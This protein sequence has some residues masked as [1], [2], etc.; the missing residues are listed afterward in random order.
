MLQRRSYKNRAEYLDAIPPFGFIIN[1]RSAA[2][3]LLQ[4]PRLLCFTRPH[5]FLLPDQVPPSRHELLRK[6][7]GF[8][9][10]HF[11]LL[12]RLFLSEHGWT[13]SQ[14]TFFVLNRVASKLALE[15]PEAEAASLVT[16]MKGIR[17]EERAVDEDYWDRGFCSQRPRGP[18]RPDLDFLLGDSMSVLSTSANYRPGAPILNN[19]TTFAY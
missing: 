6:L 12:R 15:T 8:A 7:L 1:M 11:K 14:F 5:T 2:L 18:N 19:N 13:S 16:W 17:D 4:H 10:L 3:R 9:G